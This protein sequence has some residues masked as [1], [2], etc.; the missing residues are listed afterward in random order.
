MNNLLFKSKLFLKKNS[1]T[2]LTSIGAGGVIVTSIMVAK[3]TPKAIMLLEQAKEEKGE[4]L[5]KLETVK[6]AVP[7]YIP[8]IVTGATTIACIFGANVLNKRQQAALMSAYALLDNSYKEYK[9]K[10]I[11]LYGGESDDQVKKEIV[12]DKYDPALVVEPGKTLFYD[13]Y[14]GR[15]FESTTE[16]VLRAEYELNRRVANGGAYLN[17]FYDLLGLIPTDYGDYVGWSANELFETYW[18]GWV[19]FD[20]NKVIMNDGLECMIIS[21]VTPPTHDFESW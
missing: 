20:H 12:K 9:E 17:E 13:D 21:M 3:A 6:V 11:E 7:T 16:E 4:A 14:S 18:E 10:V 2:I 15:Y 1:S 5:T 19:E 8:A